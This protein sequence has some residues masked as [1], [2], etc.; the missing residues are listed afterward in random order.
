MNTKNEII[1]LLKKCEEHYEAYKDKKYI[2]KSSIP[3]LFFG[4]IE[5]YFSSKIKIVTAAT[6]PSDIEFIEDTKPKDRFPDQKI[7]DNNY[8]AL[9]NYFEKDPYD[10]FD[11]SFE[12]ILKGIKS[13]YYSNKGFSNRA[14][15][16]DICSPLATSMKW[17]ELN[18]KYFREASKL[19]KIGQVI[20]KELIEIIQPDIILTSVRKPIKIKVLGDSNTIFWDSKSNAE[21]NNY[22]DLTEKDKP[23]KKTYEVYI[24][25]YPL[26]SGKKTKII[27]GKGNQYPFMDLD[28]STNREPR[29]KLGEYIFENLNTLGLV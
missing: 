2:V 28:F 21:R 19:K 24:N 23:R 15:H 4:D 13:S 14:I 5:E 8:T 22:Q 20:W 25:D 3:I 18:D 26:K 27:Y 17:S 7:K 1:K 11:K 6:N 12:P 10:W 29:V 16:T 9:K